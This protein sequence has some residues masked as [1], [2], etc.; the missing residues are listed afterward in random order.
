M[1]QLFGREFRHSDASHVQDLDTLEREGAIYA[2]FS[3]GSTGRFSQCRIRFTPKEI[4]EY[5]EAATAYDEFLG[6]Y[7]IT[8]DPEDALALIQNIRIRE[9]VKEYNES[10]GDDTVYCFAAFLGGD[11]ESLVCGGEDE[12]YEFFAESYSGDRKYLLREI[13][14]LFPDVATFL[15]CRTGKRPNFEISA[16]QD[17][18]DLLYAMLK[19]ILP[20]AKLEEFTP[21]HALSSKRVDICIPSM[22]LLIEVKFVRNRTHARRVADELKIDIESY[23]PHPHCDEL[24]VVV[25]DPNRHITDRRIFI[26]DLRGL[27]E[28]GG[29]RFTVEVTVQP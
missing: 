24:M 20:D 23:F 17:V 5:V 13:I 9:Q 28:K 10:A 12:R 4:V 16:E 21:Q 15:R 8:G 6:Y 22:K 25:W 19:G 7:N 18:R 2:E 14:E 27:R 11:L 26:Q 1:V 3:R 29:K